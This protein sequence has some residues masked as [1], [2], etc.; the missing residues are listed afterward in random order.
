MNSTNFAI[1]ISRTCQS[2][3]MGIMISCFSPLAWS[4][5]QVLIMTISNVEG[6]P[7]S[8]AKIDSTNAQSIASKLGYSL[9]NATILKD[10]QLTA[11]GM[12][13]ALSDFAARV[14]KNDRVFIYYSGHGASAAQGNQCV[15]V[16]V[17]QD[18]TKQAAKVVTVEE[19]ATRVEQIKTRASD[20]LVF[21]D[22]CH[23]GGMRDFVAVRGMDKGADSRGAESGLVSKAYAMKGGEAC[24]IPVNTAAKSFPIQETSSLSRGVV[25]GLP[26]SNIVYIAAANEKEEAL[27]V[28]QKGGMA[29]LAVLSCLNNGV[30]VK[31]GSGVVSAQDLV[32]CA[33]GFVH[34]EVPR[35]S[36]K[37]T[38]HH[39]EVYGNTN[40]MFAVKALPASATEANAPVFNSNIASTTVSTPGKPNV[41]SAST[42]AREKAA[43]AFMHKLAAT[44]NG[45]WGFTVQPS[46]TEVPLSRPNAANQ[47]SQVVTFNYDTTQEGYV[48]VM[49][50]GSDHEDIKMLWPAKG[51]LRKIQQGQGR[52]SARFEILGPPGVNTFLVVASQKPMD[53]GDMFPADGNSGAALNTQTFKEIGCTVMA[54]RNAQAK[55]DSDGCAGKNR[56]AMAKD[57]IQPIGTDDG[58][59]A[60]LIEIR[61]R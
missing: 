25:G 52:L 38:P 32:N 60:R 46:A 55:D 22:A 4:A 19:L 33:Q 51:Q 5:D 17:G 29:T 8:G 49:Y 20:V 34:R 57:D 11:D 14:Q 6:A 54:N 9:S 58:F 56:N 21:M 24:N 40:R 31:D 50:V 18:S 13:Q 41:S 15:Q 48:Q 23:S 36:P 12:R 45:N 43:L 7:L 16:L 30:P 44:S 59:V 26:K 10:E 47:L 61:G 37:H 39:I 3:A 1:A 53:F 28:P 42:N 2:L 27:D 35:V